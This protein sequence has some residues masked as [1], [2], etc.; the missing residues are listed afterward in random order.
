M[1]SRF[2]RP[3]AAV[4]TSSAHIAENA[5][6]TPVAIEHNT[7]PDTI[8]TGPPNLSAMRP[9]GSAAN[10]AGAANSAAI[11]A[12][13]RVSAPSAIARYPIINRTPTHPACA[14]VA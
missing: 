5:T 9:I 2:P 1:M 12:N 3:N 13:V 6:S 7:I 14:A 8:T 11:T 10:T 4:H